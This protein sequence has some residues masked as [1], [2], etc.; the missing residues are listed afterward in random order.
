MD[1]IEFVGFIALGL[2]VVMLVAFVGYHVGK[3]S[4]IGCVRKDPKALLN[5]WGPV[6][7]IIS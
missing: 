7:H 5:I 3:E 4:G 6:L 2:G 1:S